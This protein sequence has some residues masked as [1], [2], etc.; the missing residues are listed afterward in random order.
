MNSPLARLAAASSWAWALS[1]TV[2]VAPESALSNPNDSARG[3]GVDGGSAG[4]GRRRAS[5][6]DSGFDKRTGEDILLSKGNVFQTQGCPQLMTEDE[7]IAKAKDSSAPGNIINLVS[8]GKGRA[9][10]HYLVVSSY[11]AMAY[12]CK[13]K[14]LTMPRYDDTFPSALSG[15]GGHFETENR[16]FDFSHVD[17]LPLEEYEG[18]ST[19]PAVCEPHFELGGADAFH[20]WNIHDDLLS[21]MN[22]VYVRGCEAAYLEPLLSTESFSYCP[23]PAAAIHGRRLSEGGGHRDTAVA[24]TTPNRVSPST[25][26]AARALTGE[27]RETVALPTTD[28]GAGA[29]V[30][31]TRP[32]PSSGIR[33]HQDRP[34]PAR[35]AEDGS[36]NRRKDGA[37]SGDT[38]ATAA[39]EAA[40][41][42]RR[43]LGATRESGGELSADGGPQ[44]GLTSSEVGDNGEEVYPVVSGVEKRGTAGSLVIH[45]RSGD[46]FRALEPGRRPSRG[47][48]SYGQPPLQFY[49][50]AIASQ[51]WSD[52]TILTYCPLPEQLNP[53]F[54][55]LE[56]MQH[57]GML[58]PNVVTHKDRDL[59]TDIRAMLCADGLAISRSTLHFLTFAHTRAKHLFV[60]SECGP[61]TYARGHREE[62]DTRK[63]KPNPN[64]TTL[65]CIENSETEVY[66]V[67]WKVDEAAYYVY[68]NWDS[69]PEQ[70]LEMVLFDGIKGLSRCCAG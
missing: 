33:G 45:I 65:L 22:R 60:P 41:N 10:N 70:R 32:D 52:V 9:G 17:T 67:D 1:S 37:L 57:A 38:K 51:P 43:R 35:A 6:L 26:D 31:L 14:V 13:T 34:R 64:N 39:H 47:F 16:F 59:L 2:A 55:A 25:E 48:L 61:G 62:Q 30:G 3:I 36:V 53:T 23:N 49:L 58:G 66:G 40:L 44:L 46:I 54:A 50:R 8:E 24:G 11:L 18:L 42:R 12:C 19:N 27:G 21:C 28:A 15:D 68:D 63:K 7:A 56:M 29:S 69:S 4:S 20:L 5:N